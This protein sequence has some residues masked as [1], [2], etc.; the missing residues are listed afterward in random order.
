MQVDARNMTCPKP[1]I[2]AIEA[3]SKLGREKPLELLVDNETA[4]G[5]V[6]RLAAERGCLLD[7]ARRDGYTS[8]TLTPTGAA[9]PVSDSPTAGA[10]VC[11]LP[12]VPASVIAIGSDAMGRGS[13]EL[14]RILVKGLVYALA[15]QEGVPRTMLFYNSGACLT[16]E[17]S[18]SLDD[19]RELESRGTE[20][21][22][23]GTCLDFYGIREKLAVGSVTNL[24]AIA[25]AVAAQ[26]GVFSI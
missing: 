10:A 12:V 18:E 5:N 9:H 7:V 19:I 23:C 14:G 3:L 20:V 24:Y 1:V 6:S 16:C 15:H 17:G 2:L 13:D 4:V 8:L 21:L 11:D 26:P 25:E 22:T